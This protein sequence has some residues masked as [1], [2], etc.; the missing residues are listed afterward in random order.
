M[1]DISVISR[2]RLDHQKA[3]RACYEPSFLTQASLRFLW[4]EPFNPELLSDAM[5]RTSSEREGGRSVVWD[6]GNLE[7]NE[8]IKAE[9]KP[10]K[11]EEPKTPYLGYMSSDDMDTG[12]QP[13]QLEAL[14]LKI[15]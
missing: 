5:K 10:R 14:C 6:E 13:D 3:L 2:G 4:Q 8:Q 11:I 7:A 15:F 12:A 1:P 9:L